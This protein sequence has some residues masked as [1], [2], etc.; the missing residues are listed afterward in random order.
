M[1]IKAN[2]NALSVRKAYG[3]PEMKHFIELLHNFSELQRPYG[4]AM[5][6]IIHQLIKGSF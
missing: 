5:A 2:K 4:G 6:L 1:E 3:C